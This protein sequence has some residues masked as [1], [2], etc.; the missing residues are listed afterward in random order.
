MFLKRFAF[1]ATSFL[2]SRPSVCQTCQPYSSYITHSPHSPK[3]VQPHS[4]SQRR[5]LFSRPPSMAP[6]PIPD[7]VIHRGDP[8]HS[9]GGSPL[10]FIR[11]H[12]AHASRLVTCVTWLLNSGVVIFSHGLGDTSEGWASMFKQLSRGMPHVKF[13]LPT[14]PIQRVTLNGGMPM[15]SWY[16][17][18]SLDEESRETDNSD[19]IDESRDRINKI[20]DHEINE[21]KIPSNRIIVGGFSQG[22]ALSIYT[23]LQRKDTLGGVL[24]MSGYL[25]RSKD[26]I[27]FIFNKSTPILHCHGTSDPVVK[28]KWAKKSS[29]FLKEVGVNIDFKSYEGLDHGSSDEE[30]KDV[31]SWINVRLPIDVK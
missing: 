16:D 14:A 1:A 9:G 31:I 18:A 10:N 6:P 23:A 24:A 27:N 12:L 15:P 25:P 11:L 28:Y 13:I 7:V 8:P 3:L 4:S 5:G 26:A 19:G 20:I 22:G 21:N 17:I 29:D 30:V 2:S